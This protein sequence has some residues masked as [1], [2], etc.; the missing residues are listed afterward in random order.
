MKQSINNVWKWLFETVTLTQTYQ[1]ESRARRG[2][3]DTPFV[4]STAQPLRADQVY[5]S[6]LKALD[7]PEDGVFWP[8]RAFRNYLDTT[9]GFDPSVPREEVSQTIPQMLFLMN[10]ATLD[11]AGT[12]ASARTALGRLLAKES[13]DEVV[14]VERS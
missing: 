12:A 11:R 10:S 1:R 5:Y 13:D 2:V 9:F 4:A 6:V 8:N 7:L 14:R 3:N